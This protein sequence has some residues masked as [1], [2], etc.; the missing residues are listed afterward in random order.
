[1]KF[2]CVTTTPPLLVLLLLLLLFIIYYLLFIIIIKKTKKVYKI[3]LYTAANLFYIEL[4]FEKQNT[5]FHV[6]VCVFFI[7][8]LFIYLFINKKIE[9]II[10]PRSGYGILTVFP[11][12]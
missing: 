10:I 2:I 11:F 7:I 8:Y 12:D 9:T 3:T 1:V 5:L 6:C 4:K